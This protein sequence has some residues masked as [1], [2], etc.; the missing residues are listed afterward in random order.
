[1]ATAAKAS[2]ARHE[3]II[4]ITGSEINGNLLRSGV[5]NSERRAERGGASKLLEKASSLP[6]AAM[7]SSFIA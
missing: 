5:L 1:M 6:R 4:I 2:D 7:L 3:R